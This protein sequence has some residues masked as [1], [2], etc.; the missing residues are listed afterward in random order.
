MN[1]KLYGIFPNKFVFLTIPNLIKKEAKAYYY[2]GRLN[3]LQNYVES[4][5]LG[6]TILEVICDIVDNMY[7][8]RELKYVY[9]N[10]LVKKPF[11]DTNYNL[12]ELAKLIEYGNQEV[13]G[14]HMFED[15]VSYILNYKETLC[16]RG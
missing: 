4:L 14:S 3:A 9:Y 1:F 5:N 8:S 6:Y 7:I 10:L 15:I 16:S 2:S 13:K 11:K 12:S